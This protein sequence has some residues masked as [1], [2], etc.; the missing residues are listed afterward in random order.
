MVY[1]LEQLVVEPLP[2]ADCYE[3]IAAALQHIGGDYPQVLKEKTLT[4]EN[5][6]AE[7]PCDMVNFLRW[8]KVETPDG[9]QETFVEETRLPN[10]LETS[11]IY[12]NR[13]VNFYD[14]TQQYN[15]FNNS[16]R[17]SVN[18]WLTPE[19][20]L[21]WNSVLDYRIENNTFLF[22]LEKGTITMQYWAV[23]TDE[24][25]LPM[26]PDLEAFIEACMWY[27]CKQLSYQ[28]YKFKN[29]EFKMMFFEQKWN[30]YCL[31][32]RTEGRM[33]DIHMMQRMSNENMR[34]LPIT[35]HYYTSF[36]YLGI[37]QQQNRHGRFR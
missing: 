20:D 37:M 7:I 17:H 10:Y 33:P 1:R 16:I 22:N 4:I 13:R 6:R 28:G 9:Q 30:R 14:P 35:N 31:Q 2:I 19:D 3:W 15:P 25:E 8:L 23:P 12:A 26:I 29:P 34:L 27:C 36:R 32:A 11:Y 21:T 18:N 24:N 5:Y